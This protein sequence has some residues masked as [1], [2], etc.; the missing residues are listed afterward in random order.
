[1]PFGIN[2]L[3]EDYPGIFFVEDHRIRKCFH[4]YQA[5]HT[6]ENEGY[7]YTWYDFENTSNDEEDW[8]LSKK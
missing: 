8:R 7:K 4:H 6:R 2:P 1:M 3:S 5:A